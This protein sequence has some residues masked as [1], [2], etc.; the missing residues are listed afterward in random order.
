MI[1]LIPKTLLIEGHIET[2]KWPHISILGWV[3]FGWWELLN[4]WGHLG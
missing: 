4:I 3:G 2:K 1:F